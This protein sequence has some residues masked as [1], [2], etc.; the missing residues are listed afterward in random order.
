M[1]NFAKLIVQ[2]RQGNMAEQEREQMTQHYI[3]KFGR[4]ESLFKL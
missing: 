1:I 3:S 4:K 2:N